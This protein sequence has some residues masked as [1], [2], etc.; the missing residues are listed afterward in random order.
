MTEQTITTSI[1]PRGVARIT[2]NRPELHNAFNTEMINEVCD[3]MGRLVSSAE[4]RVIVITGAGSSFS[5]GADLNMMRRMAD[6]SP[7]E[8]K[9]DARRLAHMMDAIYHSPKPT[10][11]FVN[12]PALGGGLGIIAACDIA[13][14]AETAFF[15]L[16]EVRLG[17]IPAVISPFVIEAIGAR[18]ARRLF[19]TGERFSAARALEIGLLHEVAPADDL[20]AALERCLNNLLTCSPAAKFEAKE[21]IRTVAG[22]HIDEHLLDD[23]ATRIARIRASDEGK[24]GVS[25]FLEKRKPSWVKD[26]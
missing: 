5:A 3:A 23:M 25:A 22:R 19:L 9:S 16:S 20:D 4:V 11:A 24:E 21:L 6:Y 14:G 18:R 8:N 1:D 26:T 2:L 13:I 17:L 10:V 15:A 12:G 7:A